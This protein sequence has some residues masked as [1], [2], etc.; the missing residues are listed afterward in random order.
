[1]TQINLLKTEFTKR[2][3]DYLAKEKQLIA[4]EAEKTKAENM[5]TALENEL[6]QILEKTKGALNTPQMLSPDEYAELKS[7]D[8][9]VKAK[10][11]YYQALIEEQDEKIYQY[12]AT[13]HTERNELLACKKR[14][15]SALYDEALET[16]KEKHGNAL[17]ELLALLRNSSQ[18]D[19][20]IYYGEEL[21]KFAINKLFSDLGK[22]VNQYATIPEYNV[23]N[24]TP[25]FSPKRPTQLHQER[26]LREQGKLEPKGFEKLIK[27]LEQ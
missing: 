2:K 25:N 9:N 14:L 13:L 24:L 23:K 6:A 21:E 11:E 10:I 7:A 22:A 12:K 19:E 18:M 20:S 4:L 1:M 17:T 15:Y 8:F 16:F 5:K 27:N 3:N 26:V